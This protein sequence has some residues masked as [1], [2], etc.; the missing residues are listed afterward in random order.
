MTPR[1]R[2]VNWLL[3]LVAAVTSAGGR[4]AVAG[5]VA[6][7]LG[8]YVGKVLDAVELG[9]GKR[10]VRPELERLVEVDGKV[11]SIRLRLEGEKKVTSVALAGV[12]KI[13]ADRETVYET[14]PKGAG[15]QREQRQREQRAVEA[16]E[17][18][19]ARGVEPWPALSAE[20]HEAEVRLLEAFVAKVQEVFPALR[21]NHTHEFL[22]AT[23]IP[24]NL[25]APYMATLD[26]MHDL[27]CD[28]YGIPR[29]EPVWKGKCLVI[30]FLA[31]ADFVAFEAKFMRVQARGTHGLCHQGS[32]G[33]VVMACHR[34]DDEAAFAHMLV[35]ETSHGFN[36]RWMSPSRLPNW[37]NEGVA[38]WVAAKVVTKSNQVQLK[39]AVASEYMRSRGDL[40]PDFFE[41]PNIAP[42]QYGIASSMVRM[43]AGRD[44][45]KFGAFVTAIKEGTPAEE[46]LR[47]FYK[48]D[49]DGLVRA[50]GGVVGVPGLRR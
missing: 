42:E 6:D 48:Q 5:E 20:Q 33:R 21:V 2:G 29:G 4:E 18:M 50:Y 23:D 37:L 39:E 47:Q 45:K 17:R 13:V 46:A 38:E 25:M 10:F 9:S 7:R 3:L 40:G 22:V 12:V 43:L 8:P 34:G 27:L 31:E 24:P 44:A 32:D 14:V 35:H 30:A 15:R 19:R 36:H 41:R 1:R 26:A 49:T 28:L 11:T 16:A